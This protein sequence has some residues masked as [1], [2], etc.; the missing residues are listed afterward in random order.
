MKCP[1]PSPPK[2]GSTQCNIKKNGI[3]ETFVCTAS[4]KQGSWFLQGSGMPKLFNFY[5]CSQEG[6]WSG[7]MAYNME[8]LTPTD[9]TK[10]PRGQPLWPDCS[11]KFCS[12]F[13]VIS[14]NLLYQKKIPLTLTLLVSK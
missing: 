10:I 6:N 8:N 14:I 3:H 2:H 11:S 1:V 13:Y 7:T 4:C 5:F 12:I 9:V